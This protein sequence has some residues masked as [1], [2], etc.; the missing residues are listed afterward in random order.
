MRKDGDQSRGQWRQ[1]WEGDRPFW[2]K[3]LGNCAADVI[4]DAS[5]QKYS[6]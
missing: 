4:N 2:Q 3:R 5:G 6:G 1:G